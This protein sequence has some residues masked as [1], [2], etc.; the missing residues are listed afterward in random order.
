MGFSKAHQWEKVS[1]LCLPALCH[2]SQKPCDAEGHKPPGKQSTWQAQ[3]PA[4]TAE[5][6]A[7]TGKKLQLGICPLTLEKSYTRYLSFPE[8]LPSKLTLTLTLLN[9]VRI[10]FSRL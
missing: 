10:D 1:W 2:G 5:K 4:E 9:G 3:T 8:L 6:N 7:G